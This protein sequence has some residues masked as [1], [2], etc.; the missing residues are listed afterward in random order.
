[1]AVDQIQIKWRDGD[2]K[3]YEDSLNALKTYSAPPSIK[4]SVI[5]KGNYT[6]EAIDQVVAAAQALTLDANLS[7]QLSYADENSTPRYVGSVNMKSDALSKGIIDQLIAMAREMG[8]EPQLVLTATWG[9]IR[10][11]N[12]CSYSRCPSAGDVH[13]VMDSREVPRVMEG[14]DNRETL[15]RYAAGRLNSPM[16]STKGPE[17]TRTQKK[18]RERKNRR[19]PPRAKSGWP[20]DTEQGEGEWLNQKQSQR[21]RNQG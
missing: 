4:G 20:S 15:Q 14:R 1:M 19:K 13:R 6:Q 5:L 10:K 21:S 17:K 16:I 11:L 18:N 8:L 3:S 7:F 2:G 9:T 12:R